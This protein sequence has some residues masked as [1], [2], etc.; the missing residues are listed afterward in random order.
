MT[1]L[2]KD[3]RIDFIKMEKGK[4]TKLSLSYEMKYSKVKSKFFSL[5]IDNIQM[6]SEDSLS[7]SII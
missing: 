5:Q 3:K 7:F 2:Q 4:P 1:A 6:I